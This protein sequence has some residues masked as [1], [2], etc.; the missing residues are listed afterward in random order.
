[1]KQTK[2]V[3]QLGEL[4]ASVVKKL[5][6]KKCTPADIATRYKFMGKDEYL[7]GDHEYVTSE[8]GLA[9]MI[10]SKAMDDAIKILE[11]E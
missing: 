1:M 5:E 11:E 2:Q 10:Y 3:D 7:S 6:D 9:A 4:K 8:G